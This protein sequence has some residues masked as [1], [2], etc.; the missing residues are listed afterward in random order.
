MSVWFRLFSF[1]VHH[2][3][4]TVKLIGYWH[5]RLAIEISLLCGRIYCTFKLR[6]STV[7]KC[8]HVWR[9]ISIINS[10]CQIFFCNNFRNM[11][12]FSRFSLK[13]LTLIFVKWSDFQ[14]I[15]L[16]VSSVKVDLFTKPAYSYAALILMITILPSCLW[17]TNC[18][19][20]H[21]CI[22]FCSTIEG[23]IVEVITMV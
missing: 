2:Y 1:H 13:W 22:I 23:V 5:Y 3:L 6:R 15:T 10:N 9:Y 17:C 18:F 20:W 19:S 11:V 4:V 14:P 21:C 7:I 8:S 16:F 12:L